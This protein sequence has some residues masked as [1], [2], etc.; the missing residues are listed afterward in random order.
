MLLLSTAYFPPVEYFAYLLAHGKATI[1]LYETYP[2]QTWRNRCKLIT[3][4]GVADITVPVVKPLGNHTPSNQV[5]ISD[6]S[7]WKK[8]HW[9]TIHSAYRNAPYFIYYSD[10]VEDLIYHTQ[11]ELLSELNKAI[12]DVFL[13]ELKISTPVEYTS[14]FISDS[15]EHIDLRFAI[16]PK[17]RDRKSLSPLSYPVYYQLFEDRFGFVPNTSILDVLF[18]LGPDTKSYLES[19]VDS[20]PSELR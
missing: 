6:H 15:S 8:N 2:R 16:S 19:V 20:M 7:Q 17:D 18:N 5:L 1:D 10:L 3:G 9:R 12:L 13:E 4:N 14:A 11:T